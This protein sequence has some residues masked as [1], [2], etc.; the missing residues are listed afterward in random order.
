MAAVV[1][2]VSTADSF[3]KTLY[4]Q[5]RIKFLGYTNNPF[6]AI[7]PKDEN[8]VGR[9][10][11]IVC[12]YAGAAGGRSRTFA[13][14]QANASPERGE[15]FLL[16]RTKDYAVTYIETEAIL[17][18]ESDMGSFL[19]L[20]KGAVES[21]IRAAANNL[22][23]GLFRNHGGA[24]GR[25]GSINS[26][27]MTLLNINDVVNFEKDMVLVQS[28]ADGTSGS[29]GTGESLVTA[30]NRRTG[31]LTAANWTNFT[32]NDYLFQKGDF[33]ASIHGLPSWVPATAPS[34]AENF[35]GVDRSVDTRLYGQYHDGSAQ[36]IQEAIES[37]DV[38]I[39]REGGMA[40][41][42]LMNPA[43]LNAWRISLADNV[44]Y[45]M[46]RS[47]DVASVSFGAI[48]INS[49]S[50]KGIKVLADRNVPQGTAYLLQLD[51]WEL[52]SLGGAPRV[53]EGMG[54]KF[55][56]AATSDA[57]ECRIG[58]YGELGCSAPVFNAQILLPS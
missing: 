51:T 13:T 56:W 10:K 29:L 27:A 42:C 33:G 30:V 17:A 26:G 40:D 5:K 18:S 8:F 39:Y 52:S 53:L 32:A 54:N 2:T 7:V 57:V 16:T 12:H 38:K 41:T 43:D 15:D 58:Y 28:T 45:D 23:M 4:P 24:R 19:S 31:I 14:A 35:F 44:R 25:V 50:G 46:V 49:M 55:I 47:S 6:L 48:V 20:A 36:T 11:A 9:N 21:A 37:A 34:A 3:L 22:A 1:N